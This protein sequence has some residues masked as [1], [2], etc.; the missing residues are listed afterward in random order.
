MSVAHKSVSDQAAFAVDPLAFFETR[1]TGSSAPVPVSLF[2][3]PAFIVAHPDGFRHVL[4][5]RR[6]LYGK[7]EEQARMRS[8]LGD[9]LVTS[10]G[11]RWQDSRAAM[12]GSF[13]SSSLEKGMKIA[14][15]GAMGDIAAL[16]AGGGSPEDLHRVAGSITL[17]MTVAALFHQ[18]LDEATIARIYD[19]CC[20]SH[21][22]LSRVIWGESEETFTEDE[23]DDYRNA[24]AALRDVVD[25]LIDQPGGLM[26]DLWPMAGRYGHE[27]IYDEVV[28]MLV[29]GFETTAAAAAYLLYILASRADVLRWVRPDIDVLGSLAFEEEPRYLR[30]A[31]RLRAV[32]SETLRLY[33]P[34]WWFARRALEDDV[35]GGVTVPAGSSLLLSPWALHRHPDF[36]PRPLAFAPWRHLAPVDKFAFQPFGAGPRSCIG[37]NLAVLELQ[38]L[39]AM[40]L[41]SFDLTPGSGPLE[42]LRPSGGVTLGIPS[43]GLRASFAIRSTRQNPV[44]QNR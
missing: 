25:L 20:I 33:P 38:A 28:T 44:H 41:L 19:A 2:P 7:G 22:C 21:H 34:A 16:S 27:A 18:R 26:E 23:R 11:C 17:R 35:I 13:S 31:G 1:S 14:M 6:D 24:I 29:A 37:K 42:Q 10:S 5:E 4:V 30:E 3:N 15:A 8:L 32:V 40:I 39:A 36:W 43:T 9:G 12:R